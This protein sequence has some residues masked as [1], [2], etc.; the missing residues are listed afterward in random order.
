MKSTGDVSSIGTRFDQAQVLINDMSSN[1]FSVLF[2]NGLGHTIN[3]KTMAR[4][5]TED[6]YFELQSLYILNQI[7]FVGMAILSIFHLKLIFNFL[8]SKKII[9]IYVC[10]IGYALINPYMFDSNH[11]VVLI[12]LMSL[13][14]RYVKAEIEAKLDYNA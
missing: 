14:H 2:G 8:K 3:I 6:I 13:S 11:C 5:Y 4:D 9:L 7:G 10:Y 12:L 1:I